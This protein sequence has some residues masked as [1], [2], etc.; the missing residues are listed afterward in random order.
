MKP[1]RPKCDVCHKS[2]SSAQCVAR[3]KLEA[4]STGK[5]YECPICEEKFRKR[6]ELIRKLYLIKFDL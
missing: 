1:E 4:H 3:H 6:A 5:H 2:L